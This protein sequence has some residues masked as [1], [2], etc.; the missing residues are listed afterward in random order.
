MG[1]L[2]SEDDMTE[3]VERVAKA[4]AVRRGLYAGVEADQIVMN[5]GGDR[6]PYW[7]LYADDARVAVQAMRGPTEP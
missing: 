6:V 4:M 1:D 5:E 2:F 3:M 7:T